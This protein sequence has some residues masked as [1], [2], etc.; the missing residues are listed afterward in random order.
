MKRKNLAIIAIA[1]GVVALVL[2]LSDFL[3]GEFLGFSSIERV[4][5]GLLVAM[6]V[7][8]WWQGGLRKAFHTAARPD[9]ASSKIALPGGAKQFIFEKGFSAFFDEER[10]KI[11]F[12]GPGGLRTVILVREIWEPSSQ[13]P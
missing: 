11:F 7:V 1:T 5:L 2:L 3:S 4:A 13:P 9:E 12:F 10:S 6:A 8:L